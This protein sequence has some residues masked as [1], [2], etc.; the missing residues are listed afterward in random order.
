MTTY[1]IKSLSCSG[2][3]MSCHYRS[4]NRRLAKFINAN[5]MNTKVFS[6]TIFY[7]T[8][9][10]KVLILWYWFYGIE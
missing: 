7:V 4:I 5:F 3:S 10:F 9:C 8:V 2:E 1:Q 6:V